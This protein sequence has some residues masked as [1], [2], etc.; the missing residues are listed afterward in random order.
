M[1]KLFLKERASWILF[2]L[3]LQLVVLLIGYLDVSLPLQSVGYIVFLSC[4]FFLVFLIT[5]Y[6]KETRFYQEL[7]NHNQ[8]FDITTVPYANSPFEAITSEMITEQN[9]TYKSQLNELQIS[10]AQE[11]D[12][13]LNWIHEVKTP[14]TT[15]QL[16]IDRMTD[17][18]LRTQI[19]Y[20][21]LRIHLLLDQQLHQKRIPF[22]QNDLYIEKTDFQKLIFQEIKPLKLWC[23]QKGLGFDVNLEKAEVLTDAKWLGFIIR[24]LITNAVKYSESSDIQ[25]CSFVSNG[26]TTLAIRDFGRGIDARDQP[27]LFDKGFT[28]TQNHQDHTATGMGLYLTKQVA[29]A[30]HITIEVTSEIAEGTVFTLTFPKENEFVRL[31]M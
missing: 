18:P 2:F 26:K 10:V 21:W 6:Y 12:D 15:M 14:L 27:R 16:M 19:T 7:K 24:Q 4:L 8:S 25:I 11:K 1:I 29:D 20:E 30:L 9:G 13:I 3:F 28:S 23:V 5:R 22:M 31:S 17:K